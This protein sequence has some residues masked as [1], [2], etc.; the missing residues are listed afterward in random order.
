MAGAVVVAARLKDMVRTQEK[1][2]IGEDN[3]VTSSFYL[4]G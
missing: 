2:S 3:G 1:A 4:Q